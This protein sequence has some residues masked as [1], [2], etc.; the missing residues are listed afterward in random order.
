MLEA[1]REPSATAG[2][3]PEQLIRVRYTLLREAPIRGSGTSES[4]WAGVH[5]P[6][7]RRQARLSGFRELCRIIT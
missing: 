6:A 2:V 5:A 4:V 1:R 7:E 3:S